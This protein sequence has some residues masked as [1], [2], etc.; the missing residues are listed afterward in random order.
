MTEVIGVVFRCGEWIPDNLARWRA[1]IV[2]S[3]AT[4]QEEAH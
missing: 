3:E 1:V 2:V 4:E